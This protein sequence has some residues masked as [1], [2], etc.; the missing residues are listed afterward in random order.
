MYDSI[1]KLYVYVIG[2]VLYLSLERLS[3][4]RRRSFGIVAFIGLLILIGGGAFHSVQAVHC[5]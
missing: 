1:L 5:C 3:V 2:V 4:F